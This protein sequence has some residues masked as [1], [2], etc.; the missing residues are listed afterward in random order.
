MTRATFIGLLA[1][2]LFLA[3]QAG[4]DAGDFWQTYE[5]ARYLVAGHVSEVFT[6]APGF[7]AYP[8][9]AAVWA[10]PLLG[11]PPLAA[12]TVFVALSSGLLALGILRGG[13]PWRLILMLGLPFIVATR[14]A[15]WSPLITAGA[16]FPALLPLL[17]LTKPHTAVPVLLSRKASRPGL[18]L[19]AV[20]LAGS[21]LVL[22]DWPL[23]WLAQLGGYTRTIPLLD[24]PGGWLLPLALLR[25][26]DG[27][28]RL[29]LLITVLPM[30]APYDLVALWLIPRA[31]WQALA[32]TAASWLPTPALGAP[33]LLLLTA[34]ALCL[35]PTEQC[36]AG[37]LHVAAHEE[38]DL[39]SGQEVG[40]GNG[41]NR[42]EVH[43]VR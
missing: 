16:F 31:P 34:L 14:Y 2:A 32:L 29:L 24:M 37:V 1:G 9:P 38:T 18:A 27:R 30:R 35:F 7:V 41:V 26:R 28:A 4:N 17:V 11:L 40:A 21:L 23:R 39:G 25:W 42:D 20:V 19:A 22:P 10:L 36:D 3:I 5:T 8:L 33:P 12:S 13:E 6:L 43:A 15:Q